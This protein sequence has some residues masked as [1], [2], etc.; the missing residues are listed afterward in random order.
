MSKGSNTTRSGSGASSSTARV[1]TKDALQ[2]D[3]DRMFPSSLSSGSH[4]EAEILEDNIRRMISYSDEMMQRRIAT[5]TANR[6]KESQ[7]WWSKM[8]EADRRLEETD[9]RYKK[10]TGRSFGYAE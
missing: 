5:Y 10:L 8:R 3:V 7:E 2:R 9:K 6:M 1:I 4:S